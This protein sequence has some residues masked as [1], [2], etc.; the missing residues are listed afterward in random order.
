MERELNYKGVIVRPRTV[1][2][3][4]FASQQE[5]RYREQFIRE[6]QSGMFFGSG[7][8]RTVDEYIESIRG[9]CIENE[10]S[11]WD[12]QTHWFAFFPNGRVVRFPKRKYSENDEQ[13]Y[14]RLDKVISKVEKENTTEYGKFA[15]MMQRIIEQKLGARNYLIYPTTY[16]IG[17]WAIYNFHFKE[18]KSKIEEALNEMGV[19]YYNEFS[20]KNWAYRFKISKKEANRMLIASQI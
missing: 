6:K 14:S 8:D 3:E 18:D 16:G 19:E 13:F 5:K 12:R 10:R 20:D 9:L 17:L 4:E 2:F 1:T 15:A 7:Y 11:Y